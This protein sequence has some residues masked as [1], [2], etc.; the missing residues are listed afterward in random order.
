MIPLVTSFIAYM[1][2]FTT[3]L[4]SAV[5]RYVA[6]YAGRGETETGNRYL[7]SAATVL[8][9]ICALLLVP[10][11]VMA[12]NFARV[13]HVPSGQERSSGWLFLFVMLAGGA[14]ALASPYQVSTFVRHRFDLSNAVTIGTKGVLVAAIVV[15]FTWVSPSLA[16]FGVAYS[17][18]AMALL[19]ASMVLTHILTPEFRIDV[20][21][22]D[23]GAVKDMGRM[24]GWIAV[25]QLGAVLYISFGFIVINLFLG[26]EAVGR[27]GPVAQLSVL[28]STL[29]GA[30]SNVFAPIAFE[31]IARNQLQDLVLQLQRAIKL[32]G[33]AMGF[34]V[35]VLCG[36]AT[37]ILKRWLGP[38]F[39]DL[40]PLVWLLI[41]PW[42]ASIA[43]RPAFAVF[44]G[45]DKVK[46][47]GLVTCAGGIVNVCLSIV[48]IRFTGLG[49]YGVA[50][51][52]LVCLAGKNLLFTPVYTSLIMGVSKMVFIRSL[53]P[54][55]VMAL[56]LTLAGLVLSRV[57]HLATIPRLLGV[58]VMLLPI[59]AITCYSVFMTCEERRLVWSV[60]LRKELSR[61]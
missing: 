9:I 12:V 25:N 45:L 49:I 33:L 13:F 8:L 24:S 43:V 22:F 56:L 11:L 23:F 7:S 34:A 54:G 31:Y 15:F 52:L 59:Y 1:N 39:V 17:L 61:V 51:A 20:R 44:R 19:A 42:L 38:E 14:L 40:T 28:L 26:P 32:L 55:T 48:L 4:S 3:A 6:I 53:L 57:Y 35:G 2:L 36:M 41:G 30:L 58:T 18:M 29:G 5:S 47:P 10:V 46:V 21:K 27:Y 50:W 60:L 37:P 16:Y